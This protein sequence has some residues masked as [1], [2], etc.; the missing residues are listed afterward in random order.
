[1]NNKRQSGVAILISVLIIGAL[2]F[3]VVISTMAIGVSVYQSSFDLQRGVQVRGLSN[4]CFQEAIKQIIESGSA[5]GNITLSTG[6]CNYTILNLGG[7]DREIRSEGQ[8][9]DYYN[10]VK[11]IIDQIS[12]S[13]NITS[14]EE[15]S[16]F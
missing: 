3:V 8:A 13:I 10:R 11:I 5:S 6:I 14:Y 9:G 16:D 2:A 1:M 15:V 4:V 12:P 7:D